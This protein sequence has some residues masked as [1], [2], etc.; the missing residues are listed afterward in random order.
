[1]PEQKD[2][3]AWRRKL[4]ELEEGARSGTYEENWQLPSG[5]IF[6]VTGR[7]H[8]QGALAFLFED[9][10]TAIML[11]RK[12]RSE[13]ELSQATLDR[14]AEAVAVFDA[15]GMLVFVNAAFEALWG[16]DPMQRLDGPGVAA[17]AEF[18]AERCASSPV[19]ARL[20][21]FTTA[22]EARTSWTEAVETRDGR[23]L[24]LLV[25]PL[26]DASALVV[27]REPAVDRIRADGFDALALEQIRVP[28]EAAVTKLTAAIPTAPSPDAFQAL[29]AAAQALKDGLAR[30]REL[31][32]LGRESGG[33]PLPGLSALLAGR[34]LALAL[35]AEAEHWGRTEQRAAQALGL[36][37]ADLAAPGGSVTLALEAGRRVRAAIAG[38]P[39][40]RRDGIG[41]ALARRLLAAAGGSLE[42]TEAVGGVTLVAT[43]PETAAARR[44]A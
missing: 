33:G 14:M 28:V 18:W 22:A 2:F 10:S 19:W 31:E 24:E 15:A 3:A 32:A 42:L 7:P 6:R 39:T 4:G 29:S 25:A 41:V 43:L 35:P 20:A 27:F 8:P 36:A 38:A 26:P 23:R 44:C 30:A 12:Y 40:G 1:M 13:L 5:K 21:E 37:A 9:I 17:M 16:L 34:G 11:E